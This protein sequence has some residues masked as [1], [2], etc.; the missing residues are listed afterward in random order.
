MPAPS[1]LLR[2]KTV[3][4]LD[5]RSVSDTWRRIKRG[6]YKVLYVDGVPHIDAQQREEAIQQ[7]RK[8]TAAGKAHGSLGRRKALSEAHHRRRQTVGAPHTS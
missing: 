7:A 8:D 4:A 5:D 2:I 6:F 3:A 1:R